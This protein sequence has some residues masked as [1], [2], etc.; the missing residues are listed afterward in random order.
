MNICFDVDGCL[1]K[2][3]KPIK[4]N[5]ELVV[6]LSKSHKVFVWSGNGWFY[7]MQ[8]VVDLGLM[9]HINGVFNKYGTFRPDVAFDDQEIDLG[10]VNIKV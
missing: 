6:I 5:L 9:K 1:I 3:G 2:D 4:E 10:K 7:A 8:K